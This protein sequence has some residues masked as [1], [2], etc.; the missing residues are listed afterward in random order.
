MS[1]GTQMH[2]LKGRAHASL[3]KTNTL[4]QQWLA[5]LVL[6]SAKVC[7]VMMRSEGKGYL[8]NCNCVAL[9]TAGRNMKYCRNICVLP[10]PCL[11]LAFSSG[12]PTATS[13][14]K[15][16]L[17]WFQGGKENSY[18]KNSRQ[19]RLYL[20]LL[21]IQRSDYNNIKNKSWWCSLSLF[22]SFLQVFFR[23]S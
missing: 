8:Y 21:Q 13:A 23:L 19:I 20:C 22:F 17:M 4:G 3:S 9:E 11:L 5:W 10:L 16:H 2:L 18:L 12:T 6:I 7:Y 14:P 15:V 1:K